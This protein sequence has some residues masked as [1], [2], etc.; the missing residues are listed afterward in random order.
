MTASM[1]SKIGAFLFLLIFYVLTSSC[2]GMGKNPYPKH[3]MTSFDDTPVEQTRAYREYK[4]LVPGDRARISYLLWR[5]EYSNLKFWRNGSTYSGRDGAG[6]LRWK[7]RKFYPDVNDPKEFITR[8]TMHSEKTLL[9]YRVSCL[10]Y[11]DF[12][13]LSDVLTG[14]LKA[15]EEYEI[16]QAKWS[17]VTAVSEEKPATD[18]AIPEPVSDAAETVVAPTP[19]LSPSPEPSAGEKNYI[20]EGVEKDKELA[21]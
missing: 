7:M 13:N 5:M 14:E 10:P 3:S 18:E 1:R 17:A 8:V 6:W 20:D 15:L 4:T 16:E 11:G 19:T 2:A 9:P 12:H 21:V